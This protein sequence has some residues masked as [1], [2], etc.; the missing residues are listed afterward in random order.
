VIT[1]SGNMALFSDIARRRHFIVTDALAQAPKRAR[2]ETVTTKR[3]LTD[4]GGARTVEIHHI[5]GNPHAATLL[6]VYL[7]AEKLLIQ[8]DVY[9][10]P[11]ANAPAPA[12]PPAYPFAANLVDNIDRLKLEVDR[13]VPIHGPVVPIADL[14]SV[15]AANRGR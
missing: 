6:M 11:A 10:P 9:S 14:R 3:V 7:P 15:A 4:G 1:H 13:I 5:R 8:A 2:I 12:T